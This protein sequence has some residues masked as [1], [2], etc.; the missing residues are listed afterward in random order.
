MARNRHDAATESAHGRVQVGAYPAKLEPPAVGR[1]VRLR[2]VITVAVVQSGRVGRLQTPVLPRSRGV[3]DDGL[4]RVEASLQI[5]DRDD[6]SGAVLQVE[7]VGTLPDGVRDVALAS[8]EDVPVERPGPKIGRGV[9]EDRAARSLGT[10]ADHLM[11][12]L[13]VPADGVVAEGQGVIRRP[14]FDHRVCGVLDEPDEAG[15]DG[16]SDARQL[17][18]AFDTGVD[19]DDVV[20]VNDRAPGIAP[21]D[22]IIRALDTRTQRFWMFRPGQQIGRTRVSPSDVGRHRAVRIVLEEQ[23]VTSAPVDQS[24]GIVHPPRR[25][26][27][28]EAHHRSFMRRSGRGTGRSYGTCEQRRLNG[29]TRRRSLRRSTAARAGTRRCWGSGR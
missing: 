24:V 1:L 23:M 2:G 14:P 17:H 11:P 3:P 8:I 10:P 27:E 28:V 15:V 5:Q 20:A 6:Q 4:G 16:S 22:V 26:R 19:E 29:T 12:A 18:A 7:Q 13:S 25:R 9:A 21:V